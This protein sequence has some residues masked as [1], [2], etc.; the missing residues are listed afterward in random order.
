LLNATFFITGASYYI[1]YGCLNEDEFKGEKP[2]QSSW[3]FHKTEI[4]S[5]DFIEASASLKP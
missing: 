3:G 1:A 5:T 2:G 4:Y